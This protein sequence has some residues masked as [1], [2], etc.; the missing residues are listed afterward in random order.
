M[1]KLRT[2]KRIIGDRNK[3]KKGEIKQK[4]YRDSLSLTARNKT[5]LLKQK[6]LNS[7]LRGRCLLVWTGKL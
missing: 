3:K 4:N 2:N 6:R 7:P 1:K 5:P